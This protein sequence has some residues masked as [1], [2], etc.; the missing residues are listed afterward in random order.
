MS[1]TLE[2]VGATNVQVEG[3]PWKKANPPKELGYCFDAELVDD[4]AGGYVATVA[5]LPGVISEG[6]DLASAI[7]NLVEAFRAAIETYK[8]EGMPIPWRD[9]PPKEP[10]ATQLRV[11]V[12]V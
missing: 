8:T 5:Q 12:N 10:G 11:A 6:N 7:C 1:E 4:K 2:T 9:P 3:K